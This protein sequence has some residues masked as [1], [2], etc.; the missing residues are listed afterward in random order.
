MLRQ[1]ANDQRTSAL[2]MQRR[3]KQRVAW[4]CCCAS[5]GIAE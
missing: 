4:G 2:Q 1:M 3:M 5:H